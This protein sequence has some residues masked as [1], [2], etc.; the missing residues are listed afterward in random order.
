MS[1]HNQDVYG[2]ER[3][4]YEEGTNDIQASPG[5]DLYLTIDLALQQYARSLWKT[6]RAPWLLLILAQG[7]F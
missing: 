2:A 6:K 7:R 3:G 5:N 4:K 1:L